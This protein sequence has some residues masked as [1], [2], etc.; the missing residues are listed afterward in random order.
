MTDQE[1]FKRYFRWLTGFVA[2]EQHKVSPSDNYGYFT[3]LWF[4]SRK[5]FKY[6]IDMDSNRYEDGI[7]MRYRF[8]MENNISTSEVASQLDIRECSVLEMMVALAVRCE[9][10]IMADDEK[11]N[12]TALWFWEMIE[13]L[14]LSTCRNNAVY[15]PFVDICLARFM[16]H[17]YDRS[18]AGGL[19]TVKDPYKDMR[20]M[21][22]WDQAMAHLVEVLAEPYTGKENEE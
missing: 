5:P 20:T 2:D 21:E 4:L 12:R 8:A 7:D 9:E 3:L 15:E 14:G 22:I 19:F 10:H 6:S 11:G 16:N 18:G 17:E 13:S 1:M